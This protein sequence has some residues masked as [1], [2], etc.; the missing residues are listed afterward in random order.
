M[1]FFGFT[2]TELHI[3]YVLRCCAKAI[4]RFIQLIWVSELA[5]LLVA[6]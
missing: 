3:G 4:S 2:K 1:L 5:G 6:F